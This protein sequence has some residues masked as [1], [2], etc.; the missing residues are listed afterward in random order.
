VERNDL[1]PSGQEKII[2]AFLFFPSGKCC[3]FEGD[4]LSLSAGRFPLL[5]SAKKRYGLFFVINHF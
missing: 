5:G 4:M 1:P 3:P 2:E